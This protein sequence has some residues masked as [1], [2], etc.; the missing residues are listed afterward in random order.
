MGG[1]D[2]SVEKGQVVIYNFKLFRFIFLIIVYIYIYTVAM[3]S[4]DTGSYFL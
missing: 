4:N 3:F 2:G 1:I